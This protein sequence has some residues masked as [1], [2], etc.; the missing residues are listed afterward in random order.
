VN[1]SQRS[2]K[3]NRHMRRILYQSANAAVK[4]KGSIFENVYRC[5]VP[6][7][8]HKQSIGAVAHRRCRFTRKILHLG[9]RCEEPGP[10]CQ[11]KAK[12]RADGRNDPRTSQPRLSG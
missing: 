6:R 9:V 2:P 12:A 1:Y 4:A 5:T 10:G 7:L 3:G 8:G 11:Q